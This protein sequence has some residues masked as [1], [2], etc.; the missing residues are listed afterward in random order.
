[1]LNFKAHHMKYTLILLLAFFA[2]TT[3]SLFAQEEITDEV[4]QKYAVTMDSIDDMKETLLANISEK[5]QSNEEMTNDRYNELSKVIDDETKLA[6]AKATP[7]EVAFI[8]EVAQMKAD[9][10]KEISKTFQSLAKEYVGASEYNQIKKA[11][12]T[13]ASL[14]SRYDTMMAALD[15]EEVAEAN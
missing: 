2:S 11:L 8:K 12:K 13:D 4:L 6:E 1:M 15:A 7:E 5:V 10:T 14:K 3:Q 9:G